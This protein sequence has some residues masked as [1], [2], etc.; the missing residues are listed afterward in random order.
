VDEV[1]GTHKFLGSAVGL[2]AA[3]ITRLTGPR[4][5]LHEPAGQG[6]LRHF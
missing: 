2:S 1:F 4:E 3:V 5:L 6:L